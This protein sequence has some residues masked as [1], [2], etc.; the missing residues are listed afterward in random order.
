MG[1]TYFTRGRSEKILRGPWEVSFWESED[2]YFWRGAD[3]WKQIVVD[4]GQISDVR[5]EQVEGS[6]V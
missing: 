3:H 1:S 2:P 4:Y 5:G 6:L